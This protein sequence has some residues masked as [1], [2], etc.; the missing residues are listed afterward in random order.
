MTN[1]VTQS[2]ETIIYSVSH[3][4][5]T[6]TLNRPHKRN[7]LDLIMRR[8]ISSAIFQASR[9]ENVRAL[10]ITGSGGSFCS[11]G[12]IATMQSRKPGADAG[13]Q[14]MRDN[15]EW[16][17][18]LIYMGKPVIAAVDGGAVGAGFNIALAADFIV[19]SDQA[20]FCESFAKIGLVPD[21]AGLY[22]LPRIVGLQTAKEIIFSARTLSAQEAKDLSIVYRVV[23]AKSL[24]EEAWS[25]AERLC[26][27]STTSI[28]IA[29]SILNS[30]FQSELRTVL[31]LEASANG[32]CFETDYHKEAIARFLD[33]QPFHFTPFSANDSTS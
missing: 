12:D 2:F 8:E 29:K 15:W 9:D 30:S 19:A 4:I 3:S 11:G 5:A 25:L 17:Q 16:I 26:Q 13:R 10:I 24:Q 27:A 14:R 32:I 1:A 6:L 7:A 22:L 18:E 20:Y 23:P 28:G 21:L 31:D 33:K